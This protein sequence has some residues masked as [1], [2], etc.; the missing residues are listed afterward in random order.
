[1]GSFLEFS[2]IS[3]FNDISTAVGY[4]IPNPFFEN[5]SSDSIQ[6]IAWRFNTFSKVI[7]LIVNMIA[8]LEF[9]T[10][11]FEAAVQYFN[12]FFLDL[13]WIPLDIMCSSRTKALFR[14]T[15][16][17]FFSFFMLKSKIENQLIK[18]D[19]EH[20]WKHSVPVFGSE[21][22]FSWLSLDYYC[23]VWLSVSQNGMQ[24]YWA[25]L[26]E[27]LCYATPHLPVLSQFPYFSDLSSCD[28]FT[29]CSST[30]KT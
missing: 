13:N 20:V 28:Y 1:M 8:W 27:I 5:N 17:I 16:H 2:M 15:K 6:P 23:C 25:E 19:L 24:G 22:M 12:H 14:V 30:I 11:Y 21:F 4:L 3:L 9:E 7:G 10:A 29:L 26:W 18:F